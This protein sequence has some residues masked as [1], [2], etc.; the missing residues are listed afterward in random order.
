MTTFADKIIADIKQEYKIFCAWFGTEEQA[1]VIA[2]KPALLQLAKLAITDAWDIILAGAP[3]IAAAA[4]GNYE[5][6]LAGALVLI[7]NTLEKEAIILTKSALG[8]A[9]NIVVSQVEVLN[10]SGAVPIGTITQGT[11]AIPPSNLSGLQAAGT[12]GG[13]QPASQIPSS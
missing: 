1:I 4:G 8:I 12:Q 3:S 7:K 13:L 9:A 5:A 10:A 11:P 6:A 2:G